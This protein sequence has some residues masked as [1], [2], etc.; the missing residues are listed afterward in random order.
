[1]LVLFYVFRTVIS[2]DKIGR[3][4]PCMPLVDFPTKERDHQRNVD[5]S[6]RSVWVKIDF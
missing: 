5:S 3:N 4:G 6:R 2:D 1:M